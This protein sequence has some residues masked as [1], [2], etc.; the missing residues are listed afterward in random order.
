MIS[1]NATVESGFF[2]VDSVF[3]MDSTF[4]LKVNTRSGGSADQYDLGIARGMVR[5]D[6]N[7]QII[8]LGTIN[9]QMG[10]YI[11]SYAGVFR[12]QASGSMELLGQYVSGSAFFSSEGE[13]QVSFGGG[14]Q[15]GP[16]GFGVS[17]STNFSISRLDGNGTQSYGDGNY[18]VNVSGIVQ[19]TVQIFG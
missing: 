12:V 5:I 18:V 4:H 8:L 3:E 2:G 7:G 11:E 1:L 17:G 9:L 16:S 19:G 6:I 13:F 10:G 15:I 14:I